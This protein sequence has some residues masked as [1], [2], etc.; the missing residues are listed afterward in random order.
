MAKKKKLDVDLLTKKERKALFIDVA[1]ELQDLCEFE[2]PIDTKGKTEDQL[3]LLLKEAYVTLLPDDELTD[4]ATAVFDHLGLGDEAEEKEEAEEEEEAVMKVEKSEKK[5]TAKPR[6][7]VPKAEKIAFFT[8]LISKGK[9]T[10]DQ[11]IEKGM[12]KFPS[13]TKGA[14]A[15]MLTDAKNPKYNQFEKLVVV[16]SKGNLSFK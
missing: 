4:E 6:T 15:T 7:R 14:I 11:L 13:L 1:K 2:P 8:P 16:D 5:E 9:S 10:R 12:K 3:K